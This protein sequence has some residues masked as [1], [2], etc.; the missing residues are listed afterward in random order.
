MDSR[1]S[2]KLSGRVNQA[3]L[4]PDQNFLYIQ[5]FLFSRPSRM[6]SG[7]ANQAALRPDQTN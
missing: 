6:L 4:R 3:A 5:I 1:P 2:R 7:R